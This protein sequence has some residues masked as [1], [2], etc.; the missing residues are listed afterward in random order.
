[1][2]EVAPALCFAAL[3]PRAPMLVRPARSRTDSSPGALPLPAA[4]PLFPAALTLPPTAALPLLPTGALPLPTGALPLPAALLPLP[5]GS[6]FPPVE[7][8]QPNIPRN[9]FLEGSL[10]LDPTRSA[11]YLG[12]KCRLVEG[13]HQHRTGT[14]HSRTTSGKI[15]QRWEG[16]IQ[17]CR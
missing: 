15:Q 13:Q 10:Q 11:G 6:A 12:R 8:F 4:L 17:C 5:A 3:S 7:L 9:E 14:G 1:M 2:K 16:T